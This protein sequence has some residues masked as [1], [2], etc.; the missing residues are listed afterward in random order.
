[1]RLRG[2][3]KEATICNGEP[4]VRRERERERPE[5]LSI[6]ADGHVMEGEWVGLS[7]NLHRGV[8]RCPQ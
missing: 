3:G 4:A 8:T 6:A 5:A 1:M 7:L 2:N